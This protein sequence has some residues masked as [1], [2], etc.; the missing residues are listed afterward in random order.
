VRYHEIA[1][2]PH[3]CRDTIPAARIN[4]TFLFRQ[5]RV[6]LAWMRSED[7]SVQQIEAME[8]VLWPTYKYLTKL[9]SRMQQKQFADDDPL[10]PATLE[11][12]RA[13]LKLVTE[14][15]CSKSVAKPVRPTTNLEHSGYRLGRL[16]KETH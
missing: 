4:P 10:W 3:S 13:M 11:A 7:L 8:A 5:A 15:R 6:S 2:Q 9:L 1:S 16:R 14:L 12:Q